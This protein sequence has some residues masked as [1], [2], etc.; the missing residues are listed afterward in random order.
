MGWFTNKKDEEK[1]MKTASMYSAV[2]MDSYLKSRKK[3]Q[4]KLTIFDS[5]GMDDNINRLSETI[6]LLGVYDG[7]VSF[8][9][10]RYKYLKPEYSHSVFLLTQFS[11]REEFERYD[12]WLE[13]ALIQG[14]YTPGKYHM[15]DL[16]VAILETLFNAGQ[17]CLSKVITKKDGLTPEL[18]GLDSE[19]EFYDFK[20][21]TEIRERFNEELAQA[22][23]KNDG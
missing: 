7:L 11:S 5:P 8:V 16:D 14:E 10:N 9:D 6:F 21:F 20:E 17:L 12:V 19:Y 13:Q 22:L 4:D 15:R 3:H 2:I 1:I 18:T 23:N